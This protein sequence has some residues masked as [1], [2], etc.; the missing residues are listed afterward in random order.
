[1]KI[2]CTVLLIIALFIT[3]AGAATV[4]AEVRVDYSNAVLVNGMRQGLRP[5]MKVPDDGDG[6]TALKYYDNGIQKGGFDGWVNLRK[7]S[8]EKS[9][10][11]EVHIWTSPEK[12]EKLSKEKD[13][14]GN[15][16]FK[17]KR[18][19]NE[20]AQNKKGDLDPENNGD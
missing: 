20:K 8:T 6:D 5:V 9:P 17:I 10:T 15:F 4:I 16:K 2:I 11:A 19:K 18:L 3:P 7:V 1:M 14:H 12:L 13:E